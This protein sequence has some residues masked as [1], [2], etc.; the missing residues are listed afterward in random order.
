MTVEEYL[1]GFNSLYDNGYDYKDIPITNKG[2]ELTKKLFYRIKDYEYSKEDIKM[3]INNNN[4]IYFIRI[5][6]NIINKIN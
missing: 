5:F 6:L 4:N 1:K 3:F 2:R